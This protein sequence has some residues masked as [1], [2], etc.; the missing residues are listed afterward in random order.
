MLLYNLLMTLTQ[1]SILGYE[2]FFSTKTENV[3]EQ[4]KN[5]NLIKDDY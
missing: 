5:F 3:F 2:K 4:V 1:L